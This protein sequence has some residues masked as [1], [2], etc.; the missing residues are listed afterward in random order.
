V[1]VVSAGDDA[2]SE[3][4]LL[5]LVAWP[6]SDAVLPRDA[7]GPRPLCAL[8]RRGLAEAHPRAA[9]LDAVIGACD[10]SFLETADLARIDS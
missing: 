2:P 5:A 6:E 1:L 10:A 3:A 4:L 7:T 8:Y 9:S